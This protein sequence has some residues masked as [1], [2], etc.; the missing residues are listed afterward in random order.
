[1]KHSKLEKKYDHLKLKTTNKQ[2]S[3]PHTAKP[4][5]AMQSR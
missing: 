1:M 4:K 2:H 5:T 3:K